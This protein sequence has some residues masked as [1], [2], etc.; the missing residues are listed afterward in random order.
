MSKRRAEVLKRLLLAK[1]LHE[2]GTAACSARNDELSFARGLL[3]LHDAAEAGLGAIADHLN[4][5]L[6]P[7]MS[8]VQYYNAISEAGPRS[9]LGSVQHA[10][11]AQCQ[12]S[13]KAVI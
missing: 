7:Q 6:S 12:V 9:S 10:V 5:K 4:V 8:F 13:S 11:E 3:L 1:S 2:H